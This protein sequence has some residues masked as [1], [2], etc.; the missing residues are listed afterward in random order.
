MPNKNLA[1]AAQVQTMLRTNSVFVEIDGSIRRISLDNLMSSINEGNE[2]LLRQVAWGVPIKDTIQSSPVWGRVGNLDMWEEYKSLSGRY[3]VT[4]D[5]KAAKL[6]TVNS[7][8]F[9]DGTALNES[10]GHV[11][12]YAPRLYFLVKNDEVAGIPYLWMSMLPIGGHYIEAP[13][14]GA[15]KGSMSGSAL[16]SR[17]GVAPAGSKTINAF[18]S[19]AQVN[20]KNW[21]LINYDHRKFMIM[22]LLS[23]YGNP[24]AQGVLGNG[25]TGT[26]SSD[27]QTALSF[28]CGNTKSLGDSFGSVAHEYTMTNGTQTVGA[29]DVSLMGIENPYAQQWEMS[30]GVY[31]GSSNNSG[32]TGAEI[33]IYEGNRMPSS[34]ELATHPEGDYRQLTRLTSEGYISQMILGEHFDIFAKKTGGGGTSYWCDYSYANSTGQLVLWGASAAD[35]AD[36]GLGFALSDGAWSD[37]SS[38]LGSRLAYYGELTFM[39]GAELVA[40]V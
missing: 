34:S 8:V 30:Q 6:S 33:F 19:A 2:Q 22:I 10:L 21:G 31:C 16:V 13:C 14:I 18:W 28:P 24:N 7:G 40:S 5:G 36:A 38:Y 39:S 15:Y 23:E 32:Q 4:N 37:S 17:S 1:T 26:N 29:C 9:A 11:M 35:G 20:G 12:V 25:L 3:L 27:W